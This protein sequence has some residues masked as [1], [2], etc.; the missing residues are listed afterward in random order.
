MQADLRE[1]KASQAYTMK[2]C[3]KIKTKQFLG[4]E[5]WR[6]RLYL[7]VSSSLSYPVHKPHCW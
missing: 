4:L 7:C 1:F 2:A 3:L 5:R 6:L